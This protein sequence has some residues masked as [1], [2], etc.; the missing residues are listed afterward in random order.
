MKAAKII[1]LVVGVFWLVFLFLLLIASFKIPG[2]YSDL[3]IEY[4]YLPSL[5]LGNA[6]VLFLSLV[7]FS[8]F[9][10]LIRKEKRSETVKRPLLFS[11]IAGIPLLFLFIAMYLLSRIPIFVHPW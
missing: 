9:Y 5:V 10:Y 6:I 2:L 8:Y 3:D 7:N 1:S 4:N 11:I